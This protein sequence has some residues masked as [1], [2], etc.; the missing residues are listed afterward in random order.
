MGAYEVFAFW[1]GADV[2]MVLNAVAAIM[3][4]GDYLGLMKG[5]AL[6]GLISAATYALLAQR[7]QA[8]GG[9]LA[10]FVFVYGVIFVPKVDVIVND[11]RAG[12][13]SVV[14]NVPLGLAMPYATLSHIGY[15]LTLEYE[16]RFTTLD[17]ERFSKTGMVFG[18][19]VL[20]TLSQSN[21]PDPGLKADVITFYQDCVV[22][23]LMDDPSKAKLLRESKDIGTTLAGMMNPARGTALGTVTYLTSKTMSCD[24]VPT[25]INTY[26]AAD[27]LPEK[28]YTAQ[29]RINRANYGP[30]MTNAVMSSVTETDINN[31]LGNLLNISDTALQALNQSMW[32]NGINDADMAMRNGYGNAA[33]T[34]YTVAATDQSVRQSAYAGKMWADKALPLIRNI[35]EFILIAIFPLMFII[36]LVAGENALMALKLYLGILAS[37]ALWA[38]LT[39]ILNYQV[40][41]NG[42]AVLGQ[43]VK[44]S[45]GFTIN[46]LNSITDLAMQQ[47]ALAGQLFLAVPVIAYALVSAGAYAATSAMGSLTSAGSGA[48]SRVSGEAALGNVGGG[49]VGW[50]NTNALNSSTGQNTNAYKQSSDFAT[51]EGP[52][53][54]LTAATNGSG[55]SFGNARSNQTGAIGASI[56]SSV[57]SAYQKASANS[58]STAR[59]ALSE[60]GKSIREAY[61]GSARSDSTNAFLSAIDKVNSTTSGDEISKLA[62]QGQEIARNGQM[63]SN[64]QTGTTTEVGGNVSAGPSAKGQLPGVGGGA[65]GGSS[66]SLV[67]G[68]AAGASVTA[69]MKTT[70][71]NSITGTTGSTATTKDGVGNG[72]SHKDGA[73]ETASVRGTATTGTSNTNSTSSSWER[74]KD[75]ANRASAAASDSKRADEMASSTRTDSGSIN[76]DIAGQVLDRIGGGGSDAKARAMALANQDMG[77]FNAAAQ[78]AAMDIIQA[79]GYGPSASKQLKGLDGNAPVTSAAVDANAAPVEAA[80]RAQTQGAPAAAAAPKGSFKP[81]EPPSPRSKSGGTGGSNPFASNSGP[82]APAAPPRPVQPQGAPDPRDPSGNSTVTG[83]QVRVAA[84]RTAGTVAA[85]ISE[86]NGSVTSD[87]GRAQTAAGDFVNKTKK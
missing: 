56:G 14:S 13:T 67:P 51:I 11:V 76:T 60:V 77:A 19:R 53:G 28:F 58:L 54:S 68:G 24:V 82:T 39:A 71:S 7:G 3:G 5:V 64:R 74:A 36:M 40:I 81:V 50:R 10:G 80:A 62:N 8:L 31:M 52:G 33:I 78:Q 79:Q 2:N 83:G 38:P 75:A 1:N 15:W 70:D 87:T 37:L 27:A 42:K 85:Q 55:Q 63:Q 86:K 16:S 6:V 45:S 65:N 61:G 48:A 20:E 4:G 30:G 72:L 17:D 59:Q 57:Q 43:A 44:L 84:N 23:E 34:S 12:T 41:I 73:S 69:G 9:Y 22:P 26:M 46:N 25:A 47:Q 29:G 18:A 32:I 21:F 66:G 49:Q 35:A